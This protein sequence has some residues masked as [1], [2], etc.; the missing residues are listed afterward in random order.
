M[1]LLIS[2]N[3]IL[4]KKLNLKQISLKYSN[5]NCNIT[6]Q[7]I[8]RPEANPAAKTIPYYQANKEGEAGCVREVSQT[9][10]KNDK[11]LM[12]GQFRPCLWNALLFK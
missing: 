10:G 2:K 9:Q 7:E 12:N 11:F 1:D 8:Q 3:F 4:F 6:H 5:S